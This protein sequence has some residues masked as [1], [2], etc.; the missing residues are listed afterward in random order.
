MKSDSPTL[1]P[2]VIWRHEDNK[3]GAILRI[4]RVDHDEEG[5][6]RHYILTRN[7]RPIAMSG[8]ETCP[9]LAIREAFIGHVEAEWVTD[10][11]MR[12]AK[13]AVRK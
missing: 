8:D 2:N 1:L 7:G 13:S 12:A 11:P 4:Q 3:T 9:S 6:K 5:A 10:S